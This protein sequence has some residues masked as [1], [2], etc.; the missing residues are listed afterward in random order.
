MTMSSV[1]RGASDSPFHPQMLR[2]RIT[3]IETSHTKV[4][5]AV[6][7][8][9]VGVAQRLGA[10]LLPSNVAVDT[11]IAEAMQ[12]GTARLEWIDTTHNERHELTIE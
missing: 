12:T 5:L 4:T 11:L 6:P 3:D 8:T 10:Q 7:V 2:L 9:L 1:G